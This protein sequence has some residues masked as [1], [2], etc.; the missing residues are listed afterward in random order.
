MTLCSLLIYQLSTSPSCKTNHSLPMPPHSPPYLSKV[1]IPLIP[2]PHPLHLMI[3]R[4]RRRLIKY[5]LRRPPQR[6]PLAAEAEVRDARDVLV[7]VAKVVGEEERQAAHGV[8]ARAPHGEFLD[9]RG[10]AELKGLG[11]RGVVG[12]G[13]VDVVPVEEDVQGLGGRGGGGGAQEDGVEFYLGGEA[14]GVC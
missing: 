5:I 7:A 10:L 12:R 9:L 2:N 14:G 13:E 4:I 3:P 1:H 6:R 11:R 8:E